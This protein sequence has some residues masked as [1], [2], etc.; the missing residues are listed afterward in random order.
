MNGTD[1]KP[2]K[3]RSG[4]VLK[5][6]ELIEM[7]TEA[8]RTHLNEIVADRGYPADELEMIAKKVG[9]AT[10]KFADLKHNR[11]ADYIFDLEKFSKFEGYT[12]PYLLYATVRIKSILRK[13][14]E[15]GLK[16]GREITAPEKDSEKKLLLEL[17]KLPDYLQT[18]YVEGE[19]HHLCEYGFNLSQ[20]FNAFYS[21]CHILRETDSKR[22]ASW[23][24][25]SQLTHDQLQLALGLLGLSVPER[26]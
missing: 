26:M 20:A 3:T 7:I 22:Q 24:A 5:L 10:L 9:V 2:F 6:K 15:Q 25:I 13:A 12:G 16:P 17:L 8:A 11:T 1:G 14:E 23:L 18:A 4:G 19:P 21:D